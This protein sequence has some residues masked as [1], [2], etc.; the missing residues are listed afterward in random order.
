MQF[1]LRRI[2]KRNF[3]SLS[4]YGEKNG[5]AVNIEL[6]S[7]KIKCFLTVF[8]THYLACLIWQ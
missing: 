8:L 5:L 3:L 1:N 6:F 2:T 7:D 4:F